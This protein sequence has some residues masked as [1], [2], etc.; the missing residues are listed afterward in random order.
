M[1][2]PFRLGIR[3]TKRLLSFGSAVDAMH[4]RDTLDIGEHFLL[5]HV[6]VL[7]TL[8]GKGLAGGM[9]KEIL[10]DVDKAGLPIYLYTGND[11][12]EEMY[13][14]YGFVTCSQ[15]FLG[16]GDLKLV[17]RGMLRPAKVA[18]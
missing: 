18:K 2:S 7:P 17:M 1:G 4:E 5:S 16:D 6:G 10:V 14:K 15:V 11:R 3:I 13:K 12:N 8:Q 9:L